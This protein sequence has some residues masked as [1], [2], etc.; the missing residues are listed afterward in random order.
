MKSRLSRLRPS[1]VAKY[2]C[3]RFQIAPGRGLC[4]ALGH[5]DAIDNIEALTSWVRNEARQQ[6]A[7]DHVESLTRIEKNLLSLMRESEII[8]DCADAQPVPLELI[9]ELV[10][11]R[12]PQTEFMV[13]AAEEKRSQKNTASNVIQFPNKRLR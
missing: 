10:E 9:T 11:Y 2:F 6:K 3:Y 8:E 4:R 13:M 5:A 7:G 1:A 12:N